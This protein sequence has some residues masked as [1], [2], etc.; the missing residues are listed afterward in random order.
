MSMSG[1]SIAID[2][3]G[4]FTDVVL[5]HRD[6]RFWV[7]KTLM[8][9]GDLKQGFFTAVDGVMK[10]A[11]C[12][13]Y[14]IDDIIVHATTVVT[15][16]IIERKAP[17]CALSRLR[18]SATFS[19][20]GRMPLGHLR[21]PARSARGTDP[22]ELTF[23]VPER[24]HADGTVSRKVDRKA[25]KEI[26]RLLRPRRSSVAVCLLNSY[27]NPEVNGLSAEILEAAIPGSSSRC[28]AKWHHR[29]ASIRAHRRPR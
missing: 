4:T 7:D 26:A 19:D 27:K 5:R 3:G 23:A 6:G 20:P 21:Q 22:Y 25:V 10:R 18:V 17:R 2:I 12:R 9:S 29:C 1:Y 16:A 24:T 14:M 13:P 15:N 11:D 28:R 8:T